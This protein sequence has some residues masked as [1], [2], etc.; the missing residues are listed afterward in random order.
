MSNIIDY[1]KW[2]GDLS[3]EASPFNP[4][5]NLI[6]SE[7][8]YMDFGKI[9]GN[10]AKA[11]IATIA[12]DYLQSQQKDALGL[13]LTGD[14]HLMLELMATSTRYKNLVIKNCLEITDQAREIQFFAMTIELNPREAYIVFRG[15]DDTIV[16]WKEDFK[17]SFLDTIPAQE[18]ALNYLN[19]IT[20]THKY[21]QLYIGGHSKGG[22]LA[23]YAAIHSS[24]SAKKKIG[25]VYNNDGPGFSKE[26]L[27]TDDYR[28]ISDRIITLI[29]QSSIIG[30]LLEHEE[31]YQVVKSTQ[32]GALQHDGFSWEVM[33]GD[34]DYLST[35]D[36]DCIMVDM[37]VRKVLSTMSL[38]Q[39]E[40]FTNILF[41]IISVNENRTLIELKNDGFKS[42]YAMIKNYKSLDKEIKKAISQTIYLFFDEGFRS[43]LEVKN[44]DQWNQKLNLWRKDVHSRIGKHLSR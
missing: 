29:P 36:D 21:K 1:I 19:R 38:E 4:V 24:P 31:S 37:T 12:K 30:M 41:E 6:F 40:D 15:T 5:D 35:V 7:L 28:A 16:G 17:M 11:P 20:Q 2:R 44:A 3:F 18:E 23:V 8:S 42:L 10:E 27:N 32:K 26:L 43:F 14:F 39:R 22:N 9:L 13:L 25:N 33:G 34:F